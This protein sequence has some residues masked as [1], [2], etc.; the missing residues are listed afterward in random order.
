MPLFK[1]LP[2]IEEVLK[3]DS[4]DA[5]SESSSS[6]YE[7]LDETV[8]DSV[9]YDED[10]NIVYNMGSSSCSSD[11]ENEDEEP[12]IHIKNE[13]PWFT[14]EEVESDDSYGLYTY[15]PV[16][17]Y[18]CNK[19]TDDKFYRKYFGVAS[20]APEFYCVECQIPKPLEES[21]SSENSL[22]DVSSAQSENSDLDESSSSNSSVL[23]SPSTSQSSSYSEEDSDSSSDSSSEWTSDDLD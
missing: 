18:D 7:N 15:A 16:Y 5:S 12:V 21:S 8:E 20:W 11:E 3:D 19:V 2:T 4:K 6:E 1:Q 23:S 17:C 10:G 22:E 14:K 13:L 9:D